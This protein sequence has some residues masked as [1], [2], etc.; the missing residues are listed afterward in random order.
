[1]SRLLARAHRYWRELRKGELNIKTLA[2][3][4]GVSASWITRTLRLAF[5]SPEVTGAIL[6]GKQRSAIDLGAL[7]A[8]DAVRPLWTEQ[9]AVFL[10][11][12]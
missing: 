12:C 10:P 3:R 2:A 6:T 9:A 4:E 8:T 1:M 7:T 5:L 11:H